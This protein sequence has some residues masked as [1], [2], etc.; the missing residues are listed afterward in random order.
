MMAV[1]RIARVVPL[2]SMSACVSV[3]YDSVTKLQWLHRIVMTAL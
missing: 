1:R 3:C 2:V